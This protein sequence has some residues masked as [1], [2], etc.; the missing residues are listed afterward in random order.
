MYPEIYDITGEKLIQEMDRGGLDH[1]VVFPGSDY[2]LAPRMGQV[3]SRSLS[4]TRA[5]S[6]RS[7]ALTPVA[8]V[9]PRRLK[10]S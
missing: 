9:G 8:P 10:P 7:I 3:S 5:A 2:D 1:A 6:L 4:A